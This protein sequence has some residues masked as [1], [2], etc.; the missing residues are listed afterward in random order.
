MR[1][2]DGPTAG[3][4]PFPER[5]DLANSRVLARP[6]L[7]KV[8]WTVSG[9]GFCWSSCEM[10]RVVFV[11]AKFVEEWRDASLPETC[12]GK[13]GVDID[14]EETLTWPWTWPWACVVCCSFIN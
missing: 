9:G 7:E 10:T 4:P 14:S 6:R 8:G 2:V 5:T 13:E 3:D 12:A 1:G 11:G